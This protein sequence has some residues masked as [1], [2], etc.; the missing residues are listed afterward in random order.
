MQ[1]PM[2]VNMIYH[3]PN[4]K[5]HYS[6]LK[7]IYENLPKNSK[8]ILREHPIYKG[9]YEKELYKY[10][11][12]NNLSFDTNANLKESLNM[13]D[14]VIVNNST[15]GIE[16][17]AYKKPVVVLGDTYYD[18]PEICIKYN[19]ENQLK[20]VLKK[21]IAFKPK[22]QFINIFLYTFFFNHLIDGFITDKNLN[23]SDIIAK[24]VID[25]YSK[26]TINN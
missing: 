2:D 22:E 15:V 6:I 18:Y 10:A 25:Y 21:A 17:I 4:F 26:L 13:T 23:A 20:D 19:K 7:D 9:K 8:L 12:S 14:V 1:V 16:A 24:K 11:K 3:S 5:N